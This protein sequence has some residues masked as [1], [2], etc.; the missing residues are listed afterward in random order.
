MLWKGPSINDFTLR[1]GRGISKWFCSQL[2]RL[3]IFQLGSSAA[4]DEG[5]SELF[6][7]GLNCAQCLYVILHSVLGSVLALSSGSCFIQ[8]IHF[9]KAWGF[10][11]WWVHFGRGGGV[12]FSWRNVIREGVNFTPNSVTSRMDEPYPKHQDLL[13]SPR[14]QLFNRNRGLFRK[15]YN[16][17]DVKLI[18]RLHLTS[19]RGMN[20]AVILRLLSAFMSCTGIVTM[21]APQVKLHSH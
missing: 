5:L 17:R 15:E 8:A 18:F 19:M 3:L 11:T 16:G 14:S 12:I 7:V 21:C 20:G 4:I 13:C 1:A 10:I 6:Q 9:L 2:A